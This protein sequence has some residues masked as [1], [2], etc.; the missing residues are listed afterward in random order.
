MPNKF[1]TRLIC[2]IIGELYQPN[3]WKLPLNQD[4]IWFIINREK[5][6]KET[7]GKTGV[8]HS[9]VVSYV[10]QKIYDV[11]KRC[12]VGTIGKDRLKKKIEDFYAKYRD[13]RIKQRNGR[14][15]KIEY[16]KNSLEG[17]QLFNISK[18]KCPLDQDSCSCTISISSEQWKFLVDQR[19]VRLM[20]LKCKNII[21]LINFLK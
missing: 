4:A 21:V 12:G 7:H 9:E 8:R 10:F 5:Q 6:M 16:E 15:S 19:T 2:P 18:C 17:K 3:S 1:K 14:L 11:W 13:N 20:S